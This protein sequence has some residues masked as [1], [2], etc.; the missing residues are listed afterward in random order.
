MSERVCGRL[1]C[2]RPPMSR[3]GRGGNFRR[4]CSI[5]CLWWQR[6]W[7]A[8]EMGGAALGRDAETDSVLFADVLRRMDDGEDVWPEL[9]TLNDA[10]GRP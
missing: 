5:P 1:G 4:C 10:Y 8:F 3:N 6:A 7:E 9:N 2:D